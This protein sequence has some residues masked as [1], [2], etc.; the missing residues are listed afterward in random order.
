MI[1]F[2]AA[3]L[4]LRSAIWEGRGAGAGDHY[5][6]WKLLVDVVKDHPGSVLLL[7]GDVFNTPSPSGLDQYAFARGMSSLARA[8]NKVYG[9]SGNHDEED[10]YRPL[11]HGMIELTPRPVDIGGVTVAGLSWIRSSDKLVQELSTVPPVDILVTHIAFQHLIGFEGAPQCT[12]ADVPEHVGMIFNG[13]I[14]VKNINGRVYSPGSLAVNNVTEF[15]TDHGVFKYDTDTR[16]CWYIQI[17]TRNFATL[18]WEDGQ[19]PPEIPPALGA[20]LPV[21]NLIYTPGQAPEVD[22]FKEA[23]E[24]KALFLDNVQ[25]IETLARLGSPATPAA[26][27]LDAVIRQG[28]SNR[29]E[30]HPDA[31]GLAMDLASNED[32]AN[33]LERYINEHEEDE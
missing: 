14:H 21:I 30:G 7:G 5:L 10:Y 22:T 29:L 32:P 11:L 17:R 31:L 15:G 18:A 26:M 33:C 3:D 12:Q 23:N 6:A 28:I 9:I 2:F 4:H 13:H 1:V 8:G 24:G 27:D 20:N 25:N 16:K 19:E